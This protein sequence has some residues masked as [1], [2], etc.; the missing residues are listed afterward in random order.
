MGKIFCPH[1][2]LFSKLKD[3]I[4]MLLKSFVFDSTATTNTWKIFTASIDEHKKKYYKINVQDSVNNE[5]KFNFNN[6]KQTDNKNN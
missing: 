4:S 3:E 2:N 6:T 5:H 1:I